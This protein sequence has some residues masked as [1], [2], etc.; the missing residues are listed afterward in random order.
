MPEG[1][2]ISFT[3]ASL[4]YAHAHWPPVFKK[5]PAQQLAPALPR[6]H[7]L[8]VLSTLSAHI[9]ATSPKCQAIP[10]AVARANLQNVPNQ[11]V[12]EPSPS[13]RARALHVHHGRVTH[14]RVTRNGVARPCGTLRHFNSEHSLLHYRTRCASHT[15][16]LFYTS[17]RFSYQT[18][19]GRSNP[20]RNVSR[21]QT[22]LE[23]EGPWYTQGTLGQD[24]RGVACACLNYRE[25]DLTL[26]L[27]QMATKM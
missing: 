6:R 2:P 22:G 16:G 15:S 13:I 11:F 26:P 4:A 8:G 5:P 17:S 24:D 1:P 23:R 10:R 18:D 12:T 27:S 9:R 14:S 21:K 20:C 3:F 25:I 19:S 7:P